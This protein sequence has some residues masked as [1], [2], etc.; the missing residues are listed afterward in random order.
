MALVNVASKLPLAVLMQ[1][2]V[3]DPATEPEFSYEV[4]GENDPNGV[5][6]WG[7]TY[8][9]DQSAY[10]QWILDHPDKVDFVKLVTEAD[11]ADMADQTE[12]YGYQAGLD[13]G[14]TGATG[15]ARSR[16]ARGATG[17]TGHHTGS[18]GA[19]GHHAGGTGAHGR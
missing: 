8:N 7:I 18:T 2:A 15:T 16:A 5:A 17:A 19:S 1:S 13:A 11:I 9:M 10:D 14:D 6:G 12:E 3:V 4:I